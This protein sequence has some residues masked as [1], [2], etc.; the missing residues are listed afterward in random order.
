DGLERRRP[1]AC[2]ASYGS[3]SHNPSPKATQLSLPTKISKTTPCKVATGRCFE[4][5]RERFDTSPH[6]SLINCAETTRPIRPA[7]AESSGIACPMRGAL[8]RSRRSVQRRQVEP[9]ARHVLTDFDA[10]VRARGRHDHAYVAPAPVQGDRT[11]G[12]R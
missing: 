6:S 12:R 4:R 2:R 9:K 10:A 1:A 11:A 8:C 7:L 3:A 5:S